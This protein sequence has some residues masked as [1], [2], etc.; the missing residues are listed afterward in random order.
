MGAKHPFA[1]RLGE[2]VQLDLRAD[3]C[4]EPEGNLAAYAPIKG[5]TS[6]GKFMKFQKNLSLV[7]YYPSRL[8]IESG[9]CYL[10]E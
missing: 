4:F 10:H 8:K 9:I 3:D 2:D 7:S 6:N 5:Q 1:R